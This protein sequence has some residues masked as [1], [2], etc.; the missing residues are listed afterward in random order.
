M[1]A[2]PMRQNLRRLVLA[3]GYPQRH[4]LALATTNQRASETVTAL[5]TK[6]MLFLSL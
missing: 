2:I 4:M 1:I 5:L 6:S 3:E